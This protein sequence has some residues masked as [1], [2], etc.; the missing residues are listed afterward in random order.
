MRTY[1]SQ[2]YRS[3][4]NLQR[5][6]IGSNSTSTD[7]SVFSILSECP[8]SPN[9]TFNYSF[10][11]NDTCQLELTKTALQ[12]NPDLFVYANAWSAPGCMKNVGTDD[13]GGLLCGVRGSF[14]NDDE[15]SQSE[16]NAPSQCNNQDWRQAYADYLLQYVTYYQQQGINISMLGAYNEPDFNPVTYA[17]MESDG[18]QAKDF[19]E[20]LYP[21]VKAA[22]PD[23]KVACCDGTGARQE[24]DILYELLKV[25]GGNLFDVA[26]SESSSPIVI[27]EREA[28]N[29]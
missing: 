27:W 4:T 2:G 10:D 21:A 25:G 19:L 13:D 1:V 17:S 26:V 28:H 7:G 16:Q 29:F 22:Y 5:N 9:G 11:G 24:R 18:F 23:L 12:Y 6:D 8:S 14:D 3:D 20:V 15:G